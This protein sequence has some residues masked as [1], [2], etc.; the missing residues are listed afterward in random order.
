MNY[1]KENDLVH[2]EFIEWINSLGMDRREAYKFMRVA[3][4]LP[5]DKTFSH[6]GSSALYLITTLPEEERTQEQTHESCKIEAI[7][8]YALLPPYPRKNEQQA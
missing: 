1:V 2:G 8:L 6:L 7:L 5:N 3:K 4:E